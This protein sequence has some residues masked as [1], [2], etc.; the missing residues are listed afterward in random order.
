MRTLVVSGNVLDA[1]SS[2]LRGLLRTLVDTQG[3][4]AATFDNADHAVLQIQAELVVVV[5]SPERERGL[6]ALRRLRRVVPGFLLAVGE[7]TDPKLI[8]RALQSGADHYVDQDGLENELE[9]G[10]ARLQ[11]KQE[12][13]PPTGRLVAV[14][15]TSGGCGSSTMA[16]NIAAVLAKEHGGC[17]LLDLKPGR[18]D[19]AALL[20]LKP[21]FTLADLCQNVARL[22]RGMFEKMLAKHPCGVQLLGAPQTFRDTRLL[23]AHGV[24]QAVTLARKYFTHVVA[25]LEDCFHEEQVMALRQ[26]SAILLV[27]RLDF[28]ALRNARRILEHLLELEITH[29]RVRLVVNRFGQPNELPV[30]QAEEAL[31]EKLAHFVPDDPRTA[32]AANNAGIPGVLKDP[33]ARLSQSIVQLANAVFERRREPALAAATR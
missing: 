18:G 1:V 25:D 10:L 2:K 29:N 31:G 26:A 32:N 13:T 5:L 27:C 20:D 15:A 16:V 4:A 19:L 30:A 9:A 21:Q 12:A 23:T 24:G 22:D 7:V 17:A 3:P 8:L 11:I 6:E 28:T 14:L 33:S